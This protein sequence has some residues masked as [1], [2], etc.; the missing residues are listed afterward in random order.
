MFKINKDKSIYLTRGDHVS[1]ILV[2]DNN[3]KAH[4]FSKGDLVRFKVYEKKACHCVALQKDFS[5][6]SETQGVEIVLT[7]EDTKIGN[8]ISKPTDYWYEVEV[9]PET[10]PNT[11]IGYDENGAKVLKLFPEGGDKV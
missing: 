3:G 1:F 8:E 4:T 10:E 5:I 11:I 7:T 6:E 2:A 9:N